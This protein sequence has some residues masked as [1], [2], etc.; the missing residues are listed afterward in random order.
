[1]TARSMPPQFKSIL[2]TVKGS[3]SLTAIRSDDELS[4]EP[5]S[6]TFLPPIYVHTKE[7][8]LTTA[9]PTS[10]IE[11]SATSAT[12]SYVHVKVGVI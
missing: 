11:V 4:S 12:I 8:Y 6:L 10:Y 9:E 3:V 2:S 1:M 7:L 5:L